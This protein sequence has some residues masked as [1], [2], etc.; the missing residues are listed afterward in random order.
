MA[1]SLKALVILAGPRFDSQHSNGFAATRVSKT[2]VSN[3]EPMSVELLRMLKAQ[4]P[5][6]FLR[7]QLGSAKVPGAKVREGREKEG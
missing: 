1:P 2:V 4:S 5:F 7:E 3:D 6:L